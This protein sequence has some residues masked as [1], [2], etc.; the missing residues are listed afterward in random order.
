MHA[1]KSILLKHESHLKDSSTG[2]SLSL[3]I[4]YT[5][6]FT[7]DTHCSLIIQVLSIRIRIHKS[8]GRGI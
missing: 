2:L 4:E 1:F 3:G 5:K 6:H 7:A 8:I